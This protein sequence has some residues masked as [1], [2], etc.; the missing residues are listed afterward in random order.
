MR[1]IPVPP[2]IQPSAATTAAFVAIV[3][4]ECVWLLF[5]VHRAGPVLRELQ[6][7][8]RRFTF[9]TGLGLAGL[10]ALTGFISASGVL[11]ARVM[12]P[13]L[14]GFVLGSLGLAVFAAF[15][16][17][18][19]RLVHGVSIASL[20]GFQSFRLPLELVLHAWKSEGVL[21]VQMTFE[22]HN[23]DIAS[24]GLALVTALYLRRRSTA[25]APVWLFGLIGSATLAAVTAIAV[26]S[27]PLPIRRYMN[28]PPVLLAFHFPY[29]W[30]VPLCVGG[31]LFGHLLIFRWLAR[32]TDPLAQPGRGRVGPGDWL[33]E[34]H[35]RSP[36]LPR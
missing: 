21:P 24:G 3:L 32:S 19:T 13:P 30:I 36:R 11:E 23:F 4:A 15:S 12:P 8:T 22:G 6:L 10:L 28:E 25:R 31:A 9:A 33:P 16:P 1:P 29:G 18:G 26:L 5:C 34:R 35:E 7:Q 2:M 27:S 20:V 17:L 14:A